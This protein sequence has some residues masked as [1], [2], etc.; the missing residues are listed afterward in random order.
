[1]NYWISR[2]SQSFS[3]GSERVY[4]LP[5]FVIRS[6]SRSCLVADWTELA[7]FSLCLF[8]NAEAVNPLATPSE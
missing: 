6:I 1:M 3:N 8:T 5:S 7:D 4:S 2:V